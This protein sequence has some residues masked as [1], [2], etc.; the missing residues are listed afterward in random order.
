MQAMKALLCCADYAHLADSV[1]RKGGWDML[2]SMQTY[3]TGA[4]L[5]TR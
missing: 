1:E 4:T 3:H 2:M 5:L